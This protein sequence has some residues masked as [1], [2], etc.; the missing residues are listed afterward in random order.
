M[1]RRPP[2]STRTDTLFPYTTLF[3]SSPFE[4]APSAPPQDEA[5][6]SILNSGLQPGPQTLA[7]NPDL[8]LRSLRSKRLDG[9]AYSLRYRLLGHPAEGQELDHRA[10]LQT[11]QVLGQ[12]D[13]DVGGD[14]GG[15]DAGALDGE[16][17]GGEPLGRILDKT[18]SG[19]TSGRESGGQYG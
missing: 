2:R 5:I 3:R 13:A 16:R 11:G 10:R 17:L 14:Q 15:E 7:L 4:T 8:I 19:S 9:W 12:L 18:T 1:I 6:I